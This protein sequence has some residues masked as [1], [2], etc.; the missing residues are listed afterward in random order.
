VSR[1][2]SYWEKMA[3][4]VLHRLYMC[5]SEGEKLLLLMSMLWQQWDEGARTVVAQG[6][7]EPCPRHAGVSAWI[8]P[9]LETSV[10]GCLGC[11]I[12]AVRAEEKK[13]A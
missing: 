1:D 10:K 6:L 13:R 4:D 8:V 9:G 7:G 5:E 12:E 2:R 3:A 11:L